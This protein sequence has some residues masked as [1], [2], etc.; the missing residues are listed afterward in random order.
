MKSWEEQ[1]L[2]KPIVE[3]NNTIQETLTQE[4]ID[5]AFDLNHHTRNVDRIFQRVGLE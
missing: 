1:T 5:E 2:F 4:E 3:A